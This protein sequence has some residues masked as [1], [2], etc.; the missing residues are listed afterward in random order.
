M[1]GDFQQVAIF[2]RAGSVNWVTFLEAILQ[3]LADHQVLYRSMISFSMLLP[4]Q[5][6]SMLNFTRRMREAWYKLPI[7]YRQGVMNRELVINI[8]CQYTPSM[9]IWIMMK[10]KSGN[11]STTEMIEQAVTRS[12]IMAR[13]AI[14]DHIYMKPFVTV[15]LQG[16]SSPFYNMNISQAT[17]TKPGMLKIEPADAR[18]TDIPKQIIA[19]P[20]LK[21]NQM[22]STREDSGYP[23]S[24]HDKCNNCGKL[25]HWARDCPQTSTQMTRFWR[26]M[27]P[28]TPAQGQVDKVTIRGTM[29]KEDKS[30]IDF[31]R[32]KGKLRDWKVHYSNIVELYQPEDNDRSKA[33][34]LADKDK[35]D[36]LFN[37]FI[38]RILDK[39]DKQ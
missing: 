25:G 26:S 21:D 36:P 15:Q 27:S 14:E 9:S 34:T 38:Q 6:K 22:N 37:D 20:R 11:W 16:Q 3:V 5:N 30:P 1:S 8:L 12:Q 31:N 33:E 19:D 29:T 10:D 23:A 39:D 24:E 28:R 18:I 2:A 13:S 17:P 7:T 4:I 35:N 32:L